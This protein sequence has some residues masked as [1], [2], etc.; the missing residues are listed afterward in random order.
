MVVVLD[1]IIAGRRV[2]E[3]EI[4]IRKIVYEE[5]WRVGRVSGVSL[6]FWL[7]MLMHRKKQRKKAIFLVA[8]AVV[9][10]S[11]IKNIG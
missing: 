7:E 8:I 6:K 10:M 4:N 1:T 11:C 3:I 2:Q 9:C 5:V